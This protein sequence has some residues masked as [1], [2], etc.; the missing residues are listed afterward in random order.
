MTTADIESLHQQIASAIHRTLPGN[1]SEAHVTAKMITRHIELQGKYLTNGS[2]RPTS[3]LP[4]EGMESLLEAL[5]ALMAKTSPGKG[6][7]YTAVITL[8]DDGSF[9]FAFDYDQRPDFQYSPSQDKWDEDQRTF[10]R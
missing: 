1:F 10:P 9:S 8:K 3:F 4:E 5:R 7:W 6:A 2:S